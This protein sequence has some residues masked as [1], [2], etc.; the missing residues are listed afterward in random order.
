M[1]SRKTT[2][3][4]LV[5]VMVAT[6]IFAFSGIGLISLTLQ[7]RRL[8]EANVYQAMAQTIS[9]GYLEQIK[10]MAWFDLMEQVDDNGS[11]VW[12]SK[13]PIK[14]VSGIDGTTEDALSL[15]I[16]STLWPDGDPF[17][18]FAFEDY[19]YLNDVD[20]AEASEKIGQD[21]AR[22]LRRYTIVADLGSDGTNGVVSGGRQMKMLITP[23]VEP[24]LHHENH[25]AIIHLHVT[26]EVPSTTRSMH[27]N[28]FTVSAIRTRYN[29]F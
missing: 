27:R 25:G 28:S 19:N 2:G 4:T 9:Q 1:L 17:A 16:D 21:T 24:L 8:A 23:E 5:E 20:F 12:T 14:T 11:L 10:S 29:S 6:F 3:F 22:N 13:N 7:V 15:Y 26:Y 18:D